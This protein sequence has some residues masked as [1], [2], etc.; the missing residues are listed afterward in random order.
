MGVDTSVFNDLTKGVRGGIERADFRSNLNGIIIFPRILNPEIKEA[1]SLSVFKRSD[2]AYYVGRPIR[3]EQW[4]SANARERL[5]LANENVLDS[6]SAIPVRHLP[7]S[8]RKLLLSIVRGVITASGSG[9]E[10]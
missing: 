1:K 3:Y 5:A 4:Q 6:V 9:L 10:F 2:A 8:D 7:E